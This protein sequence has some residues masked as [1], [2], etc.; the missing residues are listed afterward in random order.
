[1]IKPAVNSITMQ[2]KYATSFPAK[3]DSS[4]SS[5][6]VSTSGGKDSVHINIIHTNDEHDGTFVSMAQEATVIHRLEKEH[7][8]GN[9]IIV[10]TGDLTFTQTHDQPGKDYFGPVA[11]ALNAEGVDFITPGNH[12]FQHGGIALANDFLGDLDATVLLGN[13]KESSTGK[14]LEHTKPYAIKEINGVKVG[15]IG[16]T[17]PKQKTHDHPN[18]GYD[19]T[20]E[21]PGDTAELL[22]KQA[23][24]EGARIIVVLAHEGLG[25]SASLA[26]RIPG[27]DVVVAGHDHQITREPQKVTNPDGRTSYIVEAGGVDEYDGMIREKRHVGDLGLNFDLKTGRITGIDYKLIPTAG[28][29]PD[30]EVSAIIN[31][32]KKES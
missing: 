8:E 17:T 13:V 32:Y 29:T 7:G 12:E 19:V 24:S 25:K 2:S 5:T 21:S 1:M 23:K 30:P 31:A 15:F 14:P 9:T 16:L 22:V 27:I 6:E 3:N 28:E 20:V 10:N 26:K 11:K 18:V 4:L